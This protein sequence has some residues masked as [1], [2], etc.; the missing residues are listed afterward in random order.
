[1]TVGVPHETFLDERRVSLTPQNASLLLKKGFGKVLVEKNAGA[2][3][4]FPDE[5]YTSAG[6]TLV[7]RDEVYESSDIILKVRPPTSPDEVNKLR[8]GSSL[9]SFLYPTQNKELVEQIAARNVDALAVGSCRRRPEHAFSD[10]L[11]I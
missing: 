9:I 5:L 8:Q 4:Q 3:A 1:M 11:L 7:T 10:F 2:G 6:A